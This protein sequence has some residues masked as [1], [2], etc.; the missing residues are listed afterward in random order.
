MLIRNQDEIVIYF[1][2]YVIVVRLLPNRFPQIYSLAI[3]PTLH[4]T[5]FAVSEIGSSLCN[6]RLFWSHVK[7][8]LNA[9]SLT[10]KL[11]VK[12]LTIQLIGSRT[13]FVSIAA[14]RNWI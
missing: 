5:G 3:A 9:E 12:T 11:R 14:S 1:I 8:E 10:L 4:L 2:L 13:F 6:F 7:I